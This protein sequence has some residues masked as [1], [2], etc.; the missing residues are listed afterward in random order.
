MYTAYAFQNGLNLIEQQ[1]DQGEKAHMDSIVAYSNLPTLPK[2]A[3]KC[4]NV[5]DTT[6]TTLGGMEA[7]NATYLQPLKMFNAVVTSIAGV[8]LLDRCRCIADG[9]YRSIRMLKWPLES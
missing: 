6:Q 1:E 7:F 4:I 3:V 5:F 2:T 8:R 9:C